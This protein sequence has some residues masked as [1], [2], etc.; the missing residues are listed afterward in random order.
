MTKFYLDLMNNLYLQKS[1]LFCN[2]IAKKYKP[3][4]A[5]IVF[6]MVLLHIY[7]LGTF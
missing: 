2:S 7:N 5:A 1:N 6:F 4:S 3:K